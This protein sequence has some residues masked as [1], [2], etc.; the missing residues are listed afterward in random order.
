MTHHTPNYAGLPSLRKQSP[1]ERLSPVRLIYSAGFD[2]DWTPTILARYAAVQNVHVVD[3]RLIPRWILPEWDAKHLRMLLGERYTHA[4][5]FGN[6]ATGTA[7]NRVRLDAPG[8]GLTVLKRVFE[9]GRVPMLVCNCPTLEHC[10]VSAVVELVVKELAAAHKRI[11][12]ADAR[13][14]LDQLGKSDGD[15][16]PAD[17]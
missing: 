3:C 2:D 1:L 10:H 9:R 15:T 8:D 17:L 4:G 13:R 7:R 11:T 14:Y 5:G 6:I 12:G 16:S